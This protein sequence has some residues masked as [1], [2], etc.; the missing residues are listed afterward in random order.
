VLLYLGT[1][2]IGWRDGCQRTAHVQAVRAAVGF[3]AGAMP[4]QWWDLLAGQLARESAGIAIA[5]ACAADAAP[6]QMLSVSVSIC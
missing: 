4:R 3:R 5:A 6:S 1:A 2:I